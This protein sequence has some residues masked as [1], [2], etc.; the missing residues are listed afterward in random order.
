MPVTAA[1]QLFDLLL[2]ELTHP[3]CGKDMCVYVYVYI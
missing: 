3:A 1:V 2:L